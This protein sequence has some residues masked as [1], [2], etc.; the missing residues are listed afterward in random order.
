MKGFKSPIEIIEHFKS[1]DFEMGV[2]KAY[3]WCRSLAKA[4]VYLVSKGINQDNACG[5]M[6]EKRESLDTIF[7]EIKDK[8]PA[9]PK[10]IVMP[11][12]NSTIPVVA[13]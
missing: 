3:L 13:K 8:L 6:V 1:R 11:K 7:A 2:H 5:L 12:A 10:V 9:N 4:K